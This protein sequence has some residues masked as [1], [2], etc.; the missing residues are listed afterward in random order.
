MVSKKKKATR[1]LVIDFKGHPQ[2]VQDIA[3]VAPTLPG[4]ASVKVID[5]SNGEL[6]LAEGYTYEQLSQALRAALHLRWPENY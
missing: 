1:N 4:V 5:E 3:N 6:H 2:A